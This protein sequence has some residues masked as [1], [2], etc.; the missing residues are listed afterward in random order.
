MKSRTHTHGLID[1]VSDPVEFDI[2]ESFWVQ[3]TGLVVSGILRS[4]QLITGEQYLLGPDKENQFTQVVL[5]SIHVARVQ[6]EKGFPGQLCTANLRSLKKKTTLDKDYLRNGIILVGKNSVL[7]PIWS[8]KG[9]VEILHHSS[10]ISPGYEAVMHCGVVR[11]T[12]KI[13]G[14]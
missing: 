3:G 2:H 13:T 14:M 8:L 10:T 9:T 12:V 1:E 5:K 7:K 11:Q 4:G 6:V